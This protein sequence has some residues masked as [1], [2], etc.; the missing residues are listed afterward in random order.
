MLM[1]WLNRFF[2]PVVLGLFLVNNGCVAPIV[3]DPVSTPKYA[4]FDGTNQN[5]GW[6]GY[7]DSSKS[8]GI[9]TPKAL[10][11][12]NR[13]IDKYG[14]GKALAITKGEGIVSYG[15]N[16]TITPETL[17]AFMLMSS[18]ERDAKTVSP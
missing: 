18:Y 1:L 13:L 15:D 11:R 5:S 6:V 3:P 7:T 9:I 8:L 4:S 12:L 16:Y 10:T 2:W 14:N 17:V